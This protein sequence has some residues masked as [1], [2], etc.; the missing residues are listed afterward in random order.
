MPAPAQGIGLGAAIL[1]AEC[2]V[3]LGSSGKPCTKQQQNCD[4]CLMSCA[5]QKSTSSQPPPPP[6]P[7]PSQGVTYQWQP[8]NVLKRKRGRPKKSDEGITQVRRAIIVNTMQS[9]VYEGHPMVV[10]NAPYQAAAWAASTSTN[11][12]PLYGPATIG[13]YN[14]QEAR[15]LDAA[16]LGQAQRL[17]PARAWYGPYTTVPVAPPPYAV[18][19]APAR[20][21]SPPRP[22]PPT[23]VVIP[24]IKPH[25]SL[26][27]ST[28]EAIEYQTL[29]L[30]LADLTR[31]VSTP[32]VGR[33]FDFRGTCA[34]V[35]SAPGGPS[36]RVVDVGWKIIEKTVLAFDVNAMKIQSSTLAAVTNIQTSAIWMA[37]P[38]S[39][40]PP[41][42]PKATSNSNSKTKTKTKEAEEPRCVRCEHL[43]TISVWQV[44]RRF[45]SGEMILVNLKHDFPP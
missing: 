45:V 43:L 2:T 36:A 27:H 24:L 22:P 28:S 42:D 12:G 15:R 7:P 39:I 11:S 23:R 41:A 32:H 40:A 10:A 13:W 19:P 16:R 35:G 37:A 18:P 5:R 3:A 21:P 33:E 1:C 6:P 29:A 14:P 17:E 8:P 38:H 31:L 9:T 34:V 30:L 26:P 4:H 20:P 44:Q 25:T